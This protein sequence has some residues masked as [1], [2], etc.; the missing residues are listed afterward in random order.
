[1]VIICYHRSKAWEVL[2]IKFAGSISDKVIGIFN[3]P[4]PSSCTMALVWTQPL[5]GGPGGKGRPARK[6]DNLTTIC[7]LIVYKMWE[8]RRLT[9]IWAFMPCYR[10]SCSVSVLVVGSNSAPWYCDSTP[11]TIYK[12]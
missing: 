12:R 4:D 6:A 9:I 7:E 1:M 11:E 5:A 3:W 2:S 10:D 8:S